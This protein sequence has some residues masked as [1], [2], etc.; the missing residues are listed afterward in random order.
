MQWVVEDFIWQYERET[1]WG[2]EG[3]RHRDIGKCC[4]IYDFSVL[5]PHTPTDTHI[6]RHRG[7]AHT[8]SHPFFPLKRLMQPTVSHRWRIET[9]WRGILATLL[10]GPFQCTPL[11]DIYSIYPAAATG[12]KDTEGYKIQNCNLNLNFRK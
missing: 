12:S 6:H 10:D 2:I 4:I 8:Q 1:Q 5:H 11:W 3:V 7:K 9:Q